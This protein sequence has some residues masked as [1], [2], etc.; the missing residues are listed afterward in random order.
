VHRW[1]V[2]IVLAS[3]MWQQGA[4]C[5]GDG[6][7]NCWQE[8][9]SLVLGFEQSTCCSHDHISDSNSSKEHDSHSPHSKQSPVDH[10]HHIC[11]G[12]HVFF[13]L[14]DSNLAFEVA[15]HGYLLPC[16]E[17]ESILLVE[18]QRDSEWQC[19]LAR[20]TATPALPLRAQ[21]QVFVI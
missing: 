10:R 2:T 6:T 7:A 9:V 1:V 20:R 4:C 11:L 21:L 15:D 5:C 3:L 8:L 12:S 18:I 17:P 19:R 16:H 14:D 13:V